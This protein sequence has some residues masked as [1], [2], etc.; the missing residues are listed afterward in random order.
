MPTV[1]SIARQ[2]DM[3]ADVSRKILRDDINVT[4]N[5]APV[6]IPTADGNSS[7]SGFTIR[8]NFADVLDSYGQGLENFMS[9]FDRTMSSLRESSDR[10]KESVQNREE[11]QLATRRKAQETEY[12]RRQS[13]EVF[14]DA[15]REKVQDN[16]QIREARA[17]R[18]AEVNLER[19]RDDIQEQ[20][21]GTERFANAV[22][23]RIQ[24]GVQSQREQTE[25][26]AADTRQRV[27][28]AREQTERFAQQY[29]IAENSARQNQND[30][31]ENLNST[32]QEN[33]NAALSNVRNLVD[34]FNDAV[35]YFNENRDISG[36]MSALAVNFSDR[37]NFAGLNAVGITVDD[38]GR[39]RVN[40]TRLND[41]LNENSA[42]VNELLGQNGLAGRLDRNVELANSQ[43]DNLYP[44]VADYVNEE[45]IEPTESLYALQLNQTAA[46][47]GETNWRFLNMFT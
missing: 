43:R 25:Q 41:A 37:E 5:S 22:R 15:A 7:T 42:N 35:S 1:D 19:M 3:I 46:H 29:L 21:S 47:A 44:N 27:Q 32:R 24:D 23:E 18:M 12:N 38:N 9:E 6:K 10:L 4:N 39:L 2:K 31:V 8:P 20:T 13:A 33:S 30:A 45:K 34:R 17:D 28:S 40:E 14:A 26:F 11:E 16:E 36:R